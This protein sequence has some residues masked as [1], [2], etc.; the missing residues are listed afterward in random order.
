MLA[1]LDFLDKLG[2]HTLRASRHVA[3]SLGAQ[4][5]ALHDVIGHTCGGILESAVE[6]RFPDQ[7]RQLFRRG[8]AAMNHRNRLQTG[9]FE[10]EQPRIE[11]EKPG[12]VLVVDIEFEKVMR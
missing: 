1:L 11:I 10:H 12:S 5:E 6:L 2:A 9:S 4:I 8:G 7:G 3:A